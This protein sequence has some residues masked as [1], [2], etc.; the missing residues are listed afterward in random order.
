MKKVTSQ[1]QN[2]LPGDVFV[3][4][5]GTRVDGHDYIEEALKKGAAYAVGE[6]SFPNLSSKQYLQVKDSAFTFSE[7][8]AK[9]FDFPSRKLMT[10]GITGTS[11]KTTSA[12]LVHSIL[13][14]AGLKSGL[15][16]TIHHLIGN[17]IVESTHTT[18]DAWEVQKL[19]SQMR[20]EGCKAVVMEV[21][22]HALKQKR[23]E[24]VEF[25]AALF[26]N[27]TREHLDY[28]P[29]MEDYFESKKILFSRLL[30][31]SKQNGKKAIP[32]IPDDH[33]YGS[34]LLKEIPATHSVDFEEAKISKFTVEGTE[35]EYRGVK[36][37]S[38]LFGRFNIENILGAVETGLALGISPEV[39]SRGIQNLKSV[40]GRLEAVKLKTGAYCIVD[41]AHKS[42]ALEKVLKALQE[43]KGSGKLI[44][45]FGCGGNRDREKRP[46]MGRLAVELSDQVWVTSDNPRLEDPMSI[47]EE[48]LKGIPKNSEGVSVE[49]DR[50]KAIEAA[51]RSA[52]RGDCVAILGK[53]HETYQL[54]PDPA[55]SGE[56]KKI[57]FDDREI[58]RQA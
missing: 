51:V 24:H 41:Y 36:I 13:E 28:H 2:V 35:A 21:S 15:I 22:S 37:S 16:G 44:T 57:P 10:V 17:K 56:L 7:L 1:S 29:N 9:H 18:P 43:V 27:L 39:I 42:D 49:V 4:L 14:A 46:V 34:R 3:A 12:F 53:G 58:A 11:G 33:A 38:R 23:V 48:I 26:T 6:K 5:K 31:H 30:D 47:I 54:I 19:I 8:C 32:V 25:D 40:P 50:R 20:D 45:V 55:K 52:G